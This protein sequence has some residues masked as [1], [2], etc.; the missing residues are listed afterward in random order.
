MILATARQPTRVDTLNVGKGVL[1]TGCTTIVEGSVFAVDRNDIY[2]TDG[3]G[4]IESVA[5]QKVKDYFFSN[6]SSTYFDRTRV[7]RSDVMDEVW[8]MY[9]TTASAGECD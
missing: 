9:P 8:I 3:S 5:D 7:I 1:T 6:L 4:R 2:L